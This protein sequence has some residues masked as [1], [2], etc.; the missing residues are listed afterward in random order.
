MADNCTYHI[1][2]VSKAKF[3]VSTL[4]NIRKSIERIII[5]PEVRPLFVNCLD[6]NESNRLEIYC[7]SESGKKISDEDLVE[8]L[9]V[10]EDIVGGFIDGSRVEL[11]IEIPLLEKVWVKDG[12]D[13]ELTHEETDTYLSE[14]YEDWADPDWNE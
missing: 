2:L 5:D 12:Y 4:D 9:E 8:I 3:D 13:W 6:I 1:D 7:E 11:R 14:S 10:V